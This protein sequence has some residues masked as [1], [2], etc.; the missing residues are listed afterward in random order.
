MRIRWYSVRQVPFCRLLLNR[1]GYC[2]QVVFREVFSCEFC[3][4]IPSFTER[5]CVLCSFCASRSVLLFIACRF[6]AW[7]EQLPGRGRYIKNSV[8]ELTVVSN[9]VIIAK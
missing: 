1:P 8:K 9:H 2:S 5:N 4:K 6:L 7:C 3:T